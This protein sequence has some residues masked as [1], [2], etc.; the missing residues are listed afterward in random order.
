[1]VRVTRETLFFSP[2]HIFLKAQNGP[3]NPQPLHVE[4]NRETFDCIVTLVLY[5]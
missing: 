3:L 4:L 1:M 2:F 5:L